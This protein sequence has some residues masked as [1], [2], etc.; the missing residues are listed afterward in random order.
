MLR[1]MAIL[2]SKYLMRIV[3]NTGMN[4]NRRPL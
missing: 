2:F 1:K 4:V 3:E